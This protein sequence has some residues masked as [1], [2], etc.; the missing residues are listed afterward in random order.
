MNFKKIIWILI[1]PIAFYSCDE[2][3]IEEDIIAGCMD[4]LASNFNAEAEIDAPCTYNASDV[5]VNSPWLIASAT[6][7][8]SGTEINLLELSDLIPACTLDNLFMF[9][10]NNFVSME[11]NI[12]LCENGEESVLDLSGNWTIEGNVL[13]IENGSEVYVL[14]VDN[15]SSTSMDLLFD[16]NFDV[17]GSILP[18]P[19]KIVLIQS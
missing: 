3:T 12:I 13:T 5:L 18:L 8:F 11:D 15:L 19:A 7:V 2:D 9:D 10:D 14:T 4:D 17:N 1:F 6:A 16:Y